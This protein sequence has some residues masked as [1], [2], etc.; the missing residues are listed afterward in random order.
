M[1]EQQQLPGDIYYCDACNHEVKGYHR[2]CYNCG[3]YLGS[4]TTRVD[5][6]NNSS[7]QSAF[8]FFITYLFVCL[9]VLFTNWFDSYDRLFWVEIFLA[10]F[11]LLYVWRNYEAI[12][13]VL[14]FNNFTM[15]RLLSCILLAALAAFV[16]NI[17]VTKL[18]FSF[19]RTDTSYYTRF[20][21]YTMPA[22]VMIYSIALNPAIFEELAFR[23]VLYNYLNVILDERLV[24]IITGVAFAIMHL[25]F[26]SLFW[27]IPFG[28][29][30]GTLRKRFETIWDG[31][32][33]HFTFNFVAVL[34]DLYRHG[35]LLN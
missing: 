9:A 7:L 1:A 17:I 4:D 3:E 6:F 22:V 34:F 2:Y 15:L 21:V 29:F 32:I 35:H 33:F 10:G 14:K 30:V 25:S 5:L 28:I 8:G 11:T 13:P 19:F 23:G 24:V 12:K 20:S 26:I 27:L 18:N 16:I 31:V